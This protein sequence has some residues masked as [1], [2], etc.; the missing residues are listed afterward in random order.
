MDETSSPSTR[1][2]APSEVRVEVLTCGI[3]FAQ[4]LMVEGSYQI[5]MPV[6]FSPGGEAVA[7]VAEVGTAV[8]SG[9]GLKPGDIVIVNGVPFQ[10]EA[11]WTW[12][13]S[14]ARCHL[15]RTR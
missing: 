3:G 6:P 14:S 4:T 10:E 7:V 12:A 13:A 9:R 2:V 5:K 11:G 8:A 15:R 1:H